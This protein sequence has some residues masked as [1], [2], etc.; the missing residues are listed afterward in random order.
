MSRAT[1]SDMAYVDLEEIGNTAIQRR[2]LALAEDELIFPPRER[3]ADEGWVKG[4]EG[5]K[6]W[7]RAISQ[8]R[9]CGDFLDDDELANYYIVYQRTT[10]KEYRQSG[11]HATIMVIRVLHVSLFEGIRG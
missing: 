3:N 6:A 2:L 9:F 11:V 10:D 7:R 5:A 4:H 1:W 8:K